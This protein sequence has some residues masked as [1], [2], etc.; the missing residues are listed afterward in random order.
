MIR[1][2]QGGLWRA[3]GVHPP[4]RDIL[5]KQ[6]KFFDSTPQSKAFSSS[7]A[8]IILYKPLNYPFFSGS[9]KRTLKILS[10]RGAY[11]Q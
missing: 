3:V 1:K 8:V 6:H 11:E 9:A 4:D 2:S 7:N 5:Y 10:P